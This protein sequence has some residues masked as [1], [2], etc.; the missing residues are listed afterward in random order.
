MARMV[1]LL[2][3]KLRAKD[4]PA[5]PTHANSFRG[6]SLGHADCAR[7]LTAMRPPATSGALAANTAVD[8][9]L[10]TRLAC[11]PE[12]AYVCTEQRSEQRR[13]SAS[14]AIDAVTMAVGRISQ[15]AE[16]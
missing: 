5:E 16:R 4:R 1:V 11:G 9:E 14:G 2:P 7:W 10:G 12:A 13:A 6:N 3:P 15:G 8:C